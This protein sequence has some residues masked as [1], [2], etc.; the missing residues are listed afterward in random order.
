MDTSLYNETL[1]AIPATVN[2]MQNYWIKDT[3]LY[4]S[5]YKKGFPWKQ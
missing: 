1:P 5:C 2:Y 3:Y 4:T